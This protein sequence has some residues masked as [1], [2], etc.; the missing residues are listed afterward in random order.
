MSNSRIDAGFDCGNI[1]VLSD[2]GI[3]AKLG[4]RID[5]S[6]EFVWCFHFRVNSVP[7]RALQLKITAL[8]N[9]VFQGRWPGYCGSV[10]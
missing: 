6:S 8:K 7:G 9:Y 1:E 2:S 4:I 5:A 10:T 3:M